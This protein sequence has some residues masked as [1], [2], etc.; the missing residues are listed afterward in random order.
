VRLPEELLAEAETPRDLLDAAMTVRPERT[1]L[2]ERAAVQ[3]IPLPEPAEP[4]HAQSLTE[5][6]AAHVSSYGEREHILLWQR[7]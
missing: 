6:L 5:A 7:G 3:P 1:Q 2:T 4:V